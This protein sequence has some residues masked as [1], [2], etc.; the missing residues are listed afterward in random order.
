MAKTLRRPSTS[1]SPG[2]PSLGPAGDD[3]VYDTAYVARTLDRLI[4]G[5]LQDLETLRQ[6]ASE[7]NAEAQHRQFIQLAKSTREAYEGLLQSRELL[8]GLHKQAS[9]GEVVAAVDSV[10][11]LPNSAAFQARL[12]ADLAALAPA[13]TLSLMVI[14]LGALQVLASEAGADVA[15]RIVRRFSIILRR[16]T[17][18]SDY[19]ARIGAQ[20]FAIIFED[21]LPESAI[22]IALRIHQA[23]EDKLSPS[24]SPVAGALSVTMGIAGASGPGITCPDL[25]QKAQ[26]AI[27]RAR[28]E[29]R[30]AIY[31]A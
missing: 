3:I 7:T 28:K 12:G 23:I 13:R 8:V 6:I 9:G 29:G 11:G 19:M 5:R 31:V 16:V 4:A 17:K 15:N 27:A 20:H 25:L 24:R 10:S 26:D 1:P 30:P 14:E 22:A 2:A 18:R 21:I